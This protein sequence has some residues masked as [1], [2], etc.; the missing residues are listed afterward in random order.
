M[1]SILLK[2]KLPLCILFSIS[3][4]AQ[5]PEINYSQAEFDS[6]TCCWRKLADSGKYEEG[7]NLILEYLKEGKPENKHSLK[8][9]AGQLFANAEKNTK[10]IKY[11]RK[12]SNIFYRWFGGEDGRA[13]YFYVNGTKAFLRRDKKQLQKIIKHWSNKLPEDMN[14]KQLVL[15]LENWDETYL[16]ALK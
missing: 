2:A 9:H 7:A 6:D 16:E 14:Y 11:F 12:T 3:A 4:I 15:L 13:W 5:N 10:A 8:W 1:L